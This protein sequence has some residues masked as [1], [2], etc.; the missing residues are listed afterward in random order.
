MVAPTMIDSLGE[1]KTRA[2]MVVEQRIIRLEDVVSLDDHSKPSKVERAGGGGSDNTTTAATITTGKEVDDMLTPQQRLQLDESRWRLHSVLSA[3]Q[4]HQC[5]N[6]LLQRIDA[7]VSAVWPMLRRFDTPQA[8]KRFVKACVIASG[9]GSSVGS[10][11]NITL[12]SGLPASCS[13]ERLEILDDEHHIVSFRVVGGEHRLRN[14]ASVTSLHEFEV[15]DGG[16][17]SISMAIA[18]G[19]GSAGLRC[20]S[21]DHGRTAPATLAPTRKV[22]TVVMESYVVDVPEGN[23]REDTRVFTDTVVRCNLQSLAKI[24]QANFKLEQRRCQQQQQ[25]QPEMASCKKDS[26]QDS[27]LILMR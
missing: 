4:P 5:A 7:P 8:Y 26:G 25:Q 10:L 23:T 15:S 24:C 6:L 19:G 20:S 16:G 27:G 11:R 13:T 21:G 3:A 9:D 2:G 12:I 18:T 1:N 17:G 14:Y 22:V